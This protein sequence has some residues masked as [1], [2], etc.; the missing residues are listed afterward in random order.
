M[1]TLYAHPRRVLAKRRS[2]YIK[3][4]SLIGQ[5]ND[6]VHQSA[7][8]TLALEDRLARPARS[9]PTGARPG[10]LWSA[11]RFRGRSQAPSPRS[12]SGPEA[13]RLEGDSMLIVVCQRGMAFMARRRAFLWAAS[14]TPLVRLA[15]SYLS[16]QSGSY[17]QPAGLAIGIWGHLGRCSIRLEPRKLDNDL[18]NSLRLFHLRF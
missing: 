7:E 15:V 12:R 9:L 1:H 10:S 8:R 14:T 18:V 11:P 17:C 4:G 2:P 6:P 16:H 5:V 3:S 13:G